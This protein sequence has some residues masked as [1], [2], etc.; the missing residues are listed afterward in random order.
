MVDRFVLVACITA[1][2]VSAAV[3]GPKGSEPKECPATEHTLDAIAA[4]VGATSSCEE[5]MQVFEACAYGAS[6]DV[7]LGGIVVKKCEGDFLSKLGQV[8]RRAYD[9]EQTSCN[10]KYRNE[11]GT[12][13]RSF[14]AF[15]RAQ[16]A[17][18]YSR[19]GLRAKAGGRY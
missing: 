4:A 17:Q 10:R 18:T 7:P 5:S 6:G 15:C 1:V 12:M 2:A 13:Y 3:A 14:E 9:Q 16:V 19:R 11:Q 8:Q